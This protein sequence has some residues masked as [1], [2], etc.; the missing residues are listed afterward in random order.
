M[1]TINNLLK[2]K[3]RVL[4]IIL[5][6][7]LLS[8]CVVNRN[9]TYYR[10]RAYVLEQTKV[11]TKDNDNNLY[12]ET[13]PKAT[14]LL[15]YKHDSPRKPVFAVFY[16]G[17]H[18]MNYRGSTANSHFVFVNMCS[19]DNFYR[20][21]IKIYDKDFCEQKTIRF[22]N[23]EVAKDLVCSENNL[24]VS[25]LNKETKICCLKKYDLF[26]W[27]ETVLID[28][29]DRVASFYNEEI[30][31]FF[32]ED[33]AMRKYGEKTLLFRK[34][35]GNIKTIFCDLIKASLVDNL[36]TIY[37]ESS[38]SYSSVDYYSNCFY[39]KAYLI[40]NDLLF[41]TFNYSPNEE[42]PHKTSHCICGIKES[43]LFSYNLVSEDIS[44]ISKF[45]VGSFLIDYDLTEVE[46]YK[47]GA[48]YKNDMLFR[49]CEII[50]PGDK[51]KTN[52]FD[53]KY[54]GDTNYGYVTYY[55]EDF[56]GI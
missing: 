29:L 43:Y 53:Y 1:K 32:D 31:L 47:N 13:F 52:I 4:S 16:D 50:K 17:E 3:K 6:F 41:A 33:F 27:E 25:I 38:H 7:I 21:I 28:N 11:L 48:L 54:Y 19:G 20:Y 56:Y 23:N 14:R 10:H 49:E 30:H 26:N 35:Q 46:Y 9:D 24:Y 18:R 34:E 37:G 8:S 22:E 12:A 44:L 51:E 42:C 15:K 39:E 5:M 36:V 40:D 45:Q 2:F 55:E